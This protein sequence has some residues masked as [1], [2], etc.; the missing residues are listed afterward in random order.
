MKNY[1]FLMLL[2]TFKVFK[3]SRINETRHIEWH[4]TSKCKSRLDASVCNGEQRWN[5]Y[6]CRCECKE[7]IGKGMCDKGFIWNPRNCE[8][9]CDKSCDV[10][11]YLYVN[12][13]G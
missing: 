8:Y 12:V 2:E 11:E 7:L 9:E 10:G 4:E 6:E 5:K 3:Q 1:A 13:E